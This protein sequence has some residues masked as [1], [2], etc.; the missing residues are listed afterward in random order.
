MSWFKPEAFQIALAV[1]CVAVYMTERQPG[2]VLYWVG[3]IILTAGL[4]LMR[5]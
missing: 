1:V 5:G 3:V 2:K 4:Y